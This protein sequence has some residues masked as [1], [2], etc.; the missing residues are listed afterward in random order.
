MSIP[1]VVRSSGE[2]QFLYT[3][4]LD[5]STLGPV[6]KQ[7]RASHI[8]LTCDLS[9]EALISLARLPID[10]TPANTWWADL[11]PSGGPV[12]GPFEKRS[13][14]LAAEAVWI[15]EHILKGNPHGS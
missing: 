10:E 12:L 2:V 9:D 3:E 6:A 15:Q 7:K 14:A 11:T 1:I 8:E 5:L 13:Q 4:E